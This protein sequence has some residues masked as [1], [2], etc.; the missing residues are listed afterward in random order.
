VTAS[1]IEPKIPASL[2]IVTCSNELSRPKSTIHS[3]TAITNALLHPEISF[4]PRI[5]CPWQEFHLQFLGWST[6]SN[7]ILKV[8]GEN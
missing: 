3:D 7:A 1:G 6:A 2:V 4:D 8:R 5:H